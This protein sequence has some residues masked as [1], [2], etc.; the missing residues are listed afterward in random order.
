MWLRGCLSLHGVL[1][2]I[3][4]SIC[5]WEKGFERT[6]DVGI[7]T[8]FLG[9]FCDGRTLADYC[10]FYITLIPIQMLEDYRN[11]SLKLNIN[12]GSLITPHPS[13]YQAEWPP[14]MRKSDPVVRI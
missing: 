2:G 3:L 4:V 7:W 1:W 8:M 11:L 5:I 14:S 10:T 9:S 6:L 13:L 12:R